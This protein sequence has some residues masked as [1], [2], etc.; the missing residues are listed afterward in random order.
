MGKKAAELSMNLIIV[1]VILIVALVVV[2]IIFSGKMGF[3]Q[4]TSEETSKVYNP[5]V[6]DIPGTGRYCSDICLEGDE[7]VNF[8]EGFTCRDTQ[9][10]GIGKCCCCKFT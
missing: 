8:P 6:C 10:R 4:K 2:V 1:A 7:E 9:T 3:F 5:K